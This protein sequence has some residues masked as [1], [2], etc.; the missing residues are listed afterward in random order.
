MADFILLHTLGCHLCEDAEALL[1]QLSINY[2]KKDIIEDDAL[3][4]TYG[5]RIPVLVHI[6][7]KAELGW[8][9]DLPLLSAFIHDLN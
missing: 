8:P 9:F 1:C 4:D 2:Q 5:I 7:S 6:H 3:V